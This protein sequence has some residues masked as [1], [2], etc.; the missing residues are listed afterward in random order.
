MASPSLLPF[1]TGLPLQNRRH[2]IR[3]RPACLTALDF[4]LTVR[5]TRR[6]ARLGPL[7]GR[8]SPDKLES[9]SGGGGLGLVATRHLHGGQCEPDAILVEGLLD[10]RQGPAANDEL[11]ARLGHH[12]EADLDT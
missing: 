11:L 9:L 2:F 6:D 12:L 1:P 10:K 4:L 7:L 3:S 8:G 5:E